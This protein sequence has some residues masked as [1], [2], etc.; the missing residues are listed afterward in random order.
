VVGVLGGIVSTC[1]SIKN[2]YGPKER[3]FAIRFSALCWLLLL[4]FVACMCLLPTYWRLLVLVVYSPWL[5]WLITWA[6]KGYARAKVEDMTEA[7]APAA[8]ELGL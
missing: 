1:L 6:N 4:T 2:T 7:Q 3:A 5:F 8:R